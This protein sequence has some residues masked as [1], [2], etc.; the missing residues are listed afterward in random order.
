MLP[1]TAP[2][3]LSCSIKRFASTL[4]LSDHRPA[5]ERREGA[6]GVVAVVGIEEAVADAAVVGEE[7]AAGV[8]DGTTR[9]WEEGEGGVASIKLR[10][11]E[12]RVSILRVRVQ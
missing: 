10:R 5:A 8:R 3:A 12:I 11:K 9:R 7:V 4:P 1:L 2:T 6:E